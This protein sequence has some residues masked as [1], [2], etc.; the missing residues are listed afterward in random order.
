MTAEA[1]LAVRDGR[2]RVVGGLQRQRTAGA[3]EKSRS[4]NPIW[5]TLALSQALIP[6]RL[7]TDAPFSLILILILI[8]IPIPVPIPIPIPPTE[9]WIILTT[10]TADLA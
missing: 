10:N 6:S 3:I 1:V 4:H 5:A 7:D 8:L 2:V 9:E